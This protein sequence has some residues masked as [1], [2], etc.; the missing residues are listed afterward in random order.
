MRSYW[1]TLLE[2]HDQ[3]GKCQ[4][5]KCYGQHYLNIQRKKRGS[6]EQTQY[7]RMGCA[8]ERRYRSP[9]EKQ[10]Q[11][12]YWKY[13]GIPMYYI[14]V[15]ANEAWREAECS[16][17]EECERTSGP[18]EVYHRG[19][20]LGKELSQIWLQESSDAGKAAT[21]KRRQR[22][23]DE[24]KKYS[25]IELRHALAVESKRLQNKQ[26]GNRINN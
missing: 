17:L 18:H 19:S 4:I 8:F 3:I 25:L 5:G 15:G 22:M 16:L 12:D 23:R 20:M 21:L 24:I 14:I 26:S 11:L 10:R 13:Q 1:S 7:R 9:A 2:S 6:R